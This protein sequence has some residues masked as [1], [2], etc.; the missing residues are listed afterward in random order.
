MMLWLERIDITA[1]FIFTSILFLSYLIVNKM[2]EHDKQE[3]L[4]GSFDADYYIKNGFK[5]KNVFKAFCRLFGDPHLR[6]DG[7]Y[8][9]KG[10]KIVLFNNVGTATKGDLV[11]VYNSEI[12]CLASR[13]NL[14]FEKVSNV[15]DIAL[16]DS[17]ITVNEDIFDYFAAY[18][19]GMFDTET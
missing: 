2:T 8:F 3:K 9:E 1:G 15:K 14:I 11:G 10:M 6:F 12:I 17:D 7:K 13:S 5:D 4:N 16:I 18:E 19:S